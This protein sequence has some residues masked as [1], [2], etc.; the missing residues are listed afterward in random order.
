MRFCGILVLASVLGC[1]AQD[2]SVLLTKRLLETSWMTWDLASFQGEQRSQMLLELQRARTN[3]SDIA[4]Y[5]RALALLAVNLGD[6]E[7]I[8][9]LTSKQFVGQEGVTDEKTYQTLRHA[10]H[11]ALIPALAAHLFRDEPP[12]LIIKGERAVRPPSVAA[13][14]IMASVLQSAPVFSESVRK[15]AGDKAGA[16]A[17]NDRQR[18]NLLRSFWNE[19][20]Q[21]FKARDYQS[22][23]PTGSLVGDSVQEAKPATV[24]NAPLPAVSRPLGIQ[25]LTNRS[26]ALVPPSGPRPR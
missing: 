23:R 18:R 8:K 5:G 24:T 13:A 16:A 3:T 1:C 19:N 21:H 12:G 4:R 2:S 15:W 14:D 17:I 6:E 10:T 7:L 22:V 9:E 25:A 11:P 26:G 20:R